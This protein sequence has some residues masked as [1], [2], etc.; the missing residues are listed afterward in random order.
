VTKIYLLIAVHLIQLTGI[1]KQIIELNPDSVATLR[2]PRETDLIAKGAK[3]LVFTTDGKY[4][5]VTETCAEVHRL[6]ENGRQQ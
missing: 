3:C 1:D 4:V 5:S 6:L 2:G